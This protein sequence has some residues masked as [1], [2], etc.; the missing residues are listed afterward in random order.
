MSGLGALMCLPCFVLWCLGTLSSPKS[1]S[2]TLPGLSGSSQIAFPPI[3]DVLISLV[4]FKKKKVKTTQRRRGN[5]KQ[6]LSASSRALC[7]IP[8][9]ALAQF[10]SA[11]PGHRWLRSE[12]STFLD[13]TA[14]ATPLRHSYGT[15]LHKITSSCL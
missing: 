12:E 9:Q 7:P 13:F 11:P 4:V 6:H 14:P 8:G 3:S 5:Q 15:Q 10:L 1:T 2:G